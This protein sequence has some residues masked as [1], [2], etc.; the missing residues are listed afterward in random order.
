MNK[1]SQKGKWY[2]NHY[3]AAF[4]AATQTNLL[5]SVIPHKKSRDYTKEIENKFDFEFGSANDISE[6]SVFQCYF[7]WVDND[8][9]F[10]PPQSGDEFQCRTVQKDSMRCYIIYLFVLIKKFLVGISQAKEFDPVK[11]GNFVLYKL[12]LAHLGSRTLPP[13][14]VHVTHYGR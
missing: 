5:V 4:G 7:Q 10:K 14:D 9:A 3:L 1:C 13:S 2:I 11:V 12:M 8:K 6:L